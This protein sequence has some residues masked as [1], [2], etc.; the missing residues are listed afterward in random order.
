VTAH[1]TQ[2][3]GLPELRYADLLLV[4]PFNPVRLAI[5]A[6]TFG[7][8][9][10][11]RHTLEIGFGGAAAVGSYRRIYYGVRSRWHLVTI[12]DYGRAAAGGLTVGLHLPVTPFITLGVAAHNL[13]VRGALGSELPRRLSLGASF[14]PSERFAVTTDLSKEVRA[15]ASVSAGVELS[16]VP[17]V[18]LRGG[19]ASSPP[20]LATGLGLRLARLD[21]DV[22]GVRH[23]VLGWTPSLSVALTW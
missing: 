23:D 18:A 14:S 6:S 12:R 1:G 19:V 7:F 2:L 4:A 3:Y 8:E 20:L 15:P 16:P 22:S 10:Y 17:E 13:A 9:L 5:A 21:V 11:R